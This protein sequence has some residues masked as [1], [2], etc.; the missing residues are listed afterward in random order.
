MP[1]TTTTPYMDLVLPIPTEELG[2]AWATEL[3]A[4]LTLVD[5]HD[6]TPGQGVPIPVSAIL[7]NQDFSNNNFNIANLRSTRYTNN[8]SP[9]GTP[10]DV[11]EL[12]VAGGNLYYNNQLGQQVQIT[13][14]AS[15]NAGSIGGIGGD[16]VTANALVYFTSLSDSYSFTSSG[17]LFANMFSG[18]LKIF[19]T[20]TNSFGIGIAAP[21]GLSANYNL[22]LPSSL[23]TSPS[24][25]AV[26]NAGT[27]L[28]WTPD[29]STI[30]VSGTTVQVKD[31]GI[32]QAKKAIRATGQ[33]V[34]AGGFAISPTSGAQNFSYTA[35]FQTISNLTVTITT[36][37]NPVIVGLVCDQTVTQPYTGVYVGTGT[38]SGQ[39]WAVDIINT[40]TSTHNIY[41]YQGAVS[42]TTNIA[43]M[44]QDFAPAG[45]NTYRVDINPLI[46]ETNQITVQNY[47]LV[48]YEL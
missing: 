44:T 26:N 36:L 39:N 25:L 40:T 5:S 10:S 21:G 3:N 38:G 29:N 48:A 11:T 32:T 24:F 45:I 33:T 14:G 13:A 28:Q 2:P 18:A 8:G 42:N 41:E 1:F 43:V 19:P 31:Q 6:H 47:R 23:P 16:Y 27:V 30:E 7:F 20:G 4:A 17:N 37:G 34:G 15:L 12:Y 22:T 9:L 46:N 35:G